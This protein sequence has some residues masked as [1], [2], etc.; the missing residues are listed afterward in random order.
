MSLLQSLPF[1][2]SQAGLEEVDG[3]GNYY[4]QVFDR[5]PSKLPLSTLFLLD[6]HGQL[7]RKFPWLGYDWIKQSQIDWFRNTSQALREQRRKS[8]SHDHFHLS[9]SFQHIPLPE[10][11]DSDLLMRAGYRGE[12]TEGAK[13][14][15]GFYETLAKEGI[16]AV[17]LGHDHVNDFCAIKPQQKQRGQQDANKAHQLGPWLC[18]AGSC[19]FG[20]YGEYG[21]TGYYRRARVWDLDTKA[22]RMTTWK[23]VEYA[24]ESVDELKLVDAGVVVIPPPMISETRANTATKPKP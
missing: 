8:G 16:M 3:I 1:S 22:G 18:Y 17:G 6:S 9:L 20:A 7:L 10:Y 12:P 11:G 23:R 4:L 2:L 5:A 15:L 21:G 24:T 14:N 19:G 13:F